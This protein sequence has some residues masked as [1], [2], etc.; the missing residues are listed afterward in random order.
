[1]ALVGDGVLA[2][3]D[4]VPDLDGSVSAGRNNL[5]VVG[6]ER[7]GENITSVA[8]ESVLGDTGLQVP[9]SESL[10]PRA[11]DGVSTIVRDGTVLDNVGVA[12]ERLSG[13][14]VG[15]VV[16]GEVPDDQGLISRTGQENVGVVG[17]SSER[18]NPAVVACVSMWVFGVRQEQFPPARSSIMGPS[19]V[20][21][22]PQSKESQFASRV[23][24]SAHCRVGTHPQGFLGEQEERSGSCCIMLAGP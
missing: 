13:D 1:M 11:G 6:G 22:S 23:A 2:L 14:T 17:R 18:G 9:D 16:S 3:T 7:D 21:R 19:K 10:V 5:S 20:H 24:C 4:G 15:G 12:L 8:D